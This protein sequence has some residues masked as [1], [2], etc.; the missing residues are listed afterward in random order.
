[1][2]DRAREFVAPGR[3]CR[4]TLTGPADSTDPPKDRL[5]RRV[6]VGHK[7]CQRTLAIQCPSSEIVLPSSLLRYDDLDSCSCWHGMGLL[8]LRLESPGLAAGL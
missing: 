7:P 3:H 1:M 6:P 8:V 4:S 2:N 5:F